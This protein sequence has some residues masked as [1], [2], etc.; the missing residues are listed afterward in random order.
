MPKPSATAYPV[1]FKSYIDQVP[2]EDL[3]E[4][5]KNQLPVIGSF[6]SSITEDR[7]GYAYA[8][9]KWSIREVL[10]HMIDTERIFC[11]RALCFA[12]NE[13]APLP[14][15]DENEYAAH[16]NAAVRTWASLAEEFLAVR[17]ATSR[18]FESFT[19]EA[20]LSSGI[21]SNNQL[22]VSA[23]GFITAGHFYHHKKIVEERYQ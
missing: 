20:L 14:G 3:H 8:E 17:Q 21:S 12:R 5:F 1:Y 11:Y 4:A 6:L 7:S 19:P 22:G 2:E 10:Q 18:L 15:F 16:S 13:K 9:G 23:I